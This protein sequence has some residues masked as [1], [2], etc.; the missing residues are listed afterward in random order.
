[1]NFSENGNSLLHIQNNGN[2]LKDILL[3]LFIYSIIVSPIFVIYLKVYKLNK[4]RD[5]ETAIFQIIDHFHVIN[6]YLTTA[7]WCLTSLGILL[8]F[9]EHE[10][11]AV[12][13]IMISVIPCSCVTEVNQFLLGLLAI[14]RFFI[15]FYP[16]TEKYLNFSKRTM[17]WILIIAYSISVL[18][19]V[20]VFKNEDYSISYV[21]NGSIQVFLTASALL[22]IPIVISIS[23]VANLASAKINKP[24]IFVAL[25][26][27]IVVAKQMVFLTMFL[28][29]EFFDVTPDG[30]MAEAIKS[31][32]PKFIPM[33]LAFF[34]S[35]AVDILLMPT[36]TQITYL[37]CNRRNLITLWRSLKPNCCKSNAVDPNVPLNYMENMETTQQ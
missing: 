3:I 36:I 34:N 29:C 8:Y 11:I 21:Y 31:V 32:D 19:L 9:Y 10:N 5:E 33:L 27:V 16:S 35:K 24:Q 20:H 28:V 2:T 30:F 17:K 4:T 23:K 15:Y 22:Y 18:E 37:L 25:Q 14:Q 6:K 7:F 13:L 1:M 12:V 26:L